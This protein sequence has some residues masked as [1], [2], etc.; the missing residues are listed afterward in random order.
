MLLRFHRW[1][2]QIKRPIHL[3][4]Y[5]LGVVV[6]QFSLPLSDVPVECVAAVAFGGSSSC[7]ISTAMVSAKKPFGI[8][9][10]GVD[11][12]GYKNT[13]AVMRFTNSG[14]ISAHNVPDI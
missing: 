10:K 13:A 3:S 4:A 2:E 7:A 6:I 5:R 12:E 14:M 11:F 9:G 1:Y 8:I